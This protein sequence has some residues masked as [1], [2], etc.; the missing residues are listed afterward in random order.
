MS[1]GMTFL[2]VA[3]AGATPLQAKTDPIAQAKANVAAAKKEASQAATAYSNAYSALAQIDDELADTQAKLAAAESTISVLQTK[4]SAQAKDAYIRSSSEG[5]DQEYSDVVDSVRR[6]QF[7]ATVSEF[8]D[9]QLTS[10]VGMQEDL[11]ISKDELSRLQKDRKATVTD[12]AAQKKALD[13]KLVSATK[14][15]TELEAK[16]ARDAK[17][18]KAAAAAKKASSKSSTAAGTIIST[19]SGPLVCP[20][21]GATAFTNDW[22]QPRDGGRSHKGT[23]IF[24]PRGT[25]NVA[26]VSGTVFFQNEG[27]GGISAYVTGG[28]NTYYYTH[29]K[30]TVGSARNVS[31][32]EVIGHTGSSGNASGGATHTHFEIRK[33]GPNGSRV[34]PYSTLRSIC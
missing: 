32:G 31:K 25:P 26:V 7:L 27:T 3:P 22:G 29:L 21:A 9:A 4:A 14:A 6:D 13:S 18:A 16:Q 28:G 10:L 30:N 5:E 19:S 8:D 34:N 17:A 2:V 1:I 24:S 23:D 15:Q 12:L 33:G 11:R 20:I